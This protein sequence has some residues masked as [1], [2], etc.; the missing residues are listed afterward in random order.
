[1]ACCE[2]TDVYD[3]ATRSRVM[4][5]VKSANTAPERRVRAIVRALGYGY[6]LHRKDL[7]GRP[8]LAF[9]GRR[10]VIFV[11]GCFWH[12][13]DCARGA[14]V[15]KTRTA[16]WRAKIARTRARDVAHHAAYAEM[17][18]SALTIWECELKAPEL[19]DR[20]AAFLAG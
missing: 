12:G 17:G 3:P 1:M 8:D 13:H 14:R 20:L 5:A 10:K 11:H 16:Y 18:W 19:S 9:I 4:A 7:P 15:P 2:P 6:R